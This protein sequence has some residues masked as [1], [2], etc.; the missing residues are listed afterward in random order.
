[1]AILTN[2]QYYAKLNDKSIVVQPE[3]GFQNKT[4]ADYIEDLDTKKIADYQAYWQAITPQ[5]DEEHYKR[6]LFAFLSVHCGWKANVK[7]YL[8]V[9]R[10]TFKSKAELTEI[11]ASSGVGLTTMRS[12]GMWEFTQT[13]YANP[14][15]WRKK[16][17]ET[18]DMFRHR[19]MNQ[20]HG[21]G[22]AKTAFAIE[23]CYPNECEVTCLD[24]HMLQL[25]GQKSSPVP[26]PSRYKTLEQHWVVQC[27]LKNIPAFMARNVY[28]DK[29]QSQNDT[30]YWSYVFE[31]PGF[32][33]QGEVFTRG[34]NEVLEQV[35]LQNTTPARA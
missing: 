9:T 17:T 2:A 31:Q 14:G 23:L 25:Y 16:P 34:T 13:F 3:T 5:T 22:Y 1:M 18:W 35:C 21:L 10:E 32:N 6:W 8:N 33:K 15:F 4:V 19:T 28:W 24:T 26:S 29:V 7:G 12:K 20:V 27:K 30:R 11:I